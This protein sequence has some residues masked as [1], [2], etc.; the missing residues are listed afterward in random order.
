[1]SSFARIFNTNFGGLHE[2]M[3]EIIFK[4]ESY[5]IV[6]VCMEVHKNLGVGFR[7]TV[8]KDAL[9][10]EFNNRQIPFIREKRNEIEYK[11][12]ILPHKY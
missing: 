4:K 6:G 5:E 3:V 7:E 12:V 8:Y 1:V 11:G 10:V 2:I 9:E